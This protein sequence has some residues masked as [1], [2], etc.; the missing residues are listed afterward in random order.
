MEENRNLLTVKGISK[1][2]YKREVEIRAVDRA[3][4][5]IRRGEWITLWGPSGSGKST[6]LYLLGTLLQPDEGTYQFEDEMLAGTASLDYISTTNDKKLSA[7]RAEKIGFIFQ[8]YNLL[9]D[10]TALENV[11][12]P[13]KYLVN[14]KPESEVRQRAEA[15]LKQV[16]MTDRMEH[17]PGELSGGQEQRVAIARAMMNKPSLLLADEPTGNLDSANHNMVLELMRELNREGVTV[18]VASHNPEVA[19]IADRVVKLKDGKI[20]E[21]ASRI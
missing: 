7:F 6:L 17:F 20:D 1:I 4:L 15:L 16:D 3:D 8:D 21:I 18:I 2:Y 14:P 13:A 5:D 12:Q 11:M 10:K 9:D 19:E